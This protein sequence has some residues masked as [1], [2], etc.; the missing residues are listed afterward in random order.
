M[1]DQPDVLFGLGEPTGETLHGAEWVERKV[2][3]GHQHVVVQLVHQITVIC[4]ISSQK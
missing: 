3:V 1:S 2:L 4:D